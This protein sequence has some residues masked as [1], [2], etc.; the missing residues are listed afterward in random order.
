MVK[1][2]L[3]QCCRGDAL[4]PLRP[5]LDTVVLY[6]AVVRYRD[7]LCYRDQ[8][9]VNSRKSDSAV[10]VKCSVLLLNF[11]CTYTTKHGMENDLE[12]V[13]TLD[14][15]SLCKPWLDYAIFCHRIPF[16]K[17]YLFNEVLITKH[18]VRSG[19]LKTTYDGHF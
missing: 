5:N 18:G 8:H 6:R 17:F 1:G 3:A 10:I 19:N 13:W 9:I 11:R 4:Y 12:R 7:R 15:S 16:L 2:L 14:V